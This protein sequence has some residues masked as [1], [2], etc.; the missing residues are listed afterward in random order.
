MYSFEPNEEQK[1]LTEAVNRYAV[2]ELRP[3]AREAEESGELP[4]K[5]INKGWELG[6]IQASI[7]EAY[8]GFGD[9]SA[10]T[11]VLALEELAFGD[12]AFSFAIGCPGL[13]ALPI[14]LVGS[15][16][17]KQDYL[18]EIAKDSW[19]PYTAGLI[20]HSFDFDPLALKTTA[21]AMGDQYVLNGQKFYVPFAREAK[22]LLIYANLEDQTQGFIVPKETAGLSVSEE[23]GKLMS[24][25]A[26]P[27]LSGEPGGRQGAEL[28]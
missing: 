18:P 4:K 7:P 25:N 15:E 9:R 23:K 10:L 26:I 17:Q 1:M 16:Q 2:T 6:L 19:Q 21:R 13:F 27:S 14:L 22:A 5:L 8:G 12:L 11:G 28:Q 3:A 24:L 20:E